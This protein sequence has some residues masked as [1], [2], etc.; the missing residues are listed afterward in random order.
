M[1]GYVGLQDSHTGPGGTIEYRNIRIKELGPQAPFRAL[2]FSKTAGFRHGSIPVGIEAI[3]KLG[4]THGF[5]VDATEDAATFTDDALS[6][7]AAVVFL[8]TTG[9]VLDPE[10]QAA[11]E[12]FIRHIRAR[13]RAWIGS[14]KLGRTKRWRKLA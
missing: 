13:P 8:N 10:Q 1:V 9:D 4:E 2:V 12:R 7:Y 3:R 6:R 5:E 11:F 14:F